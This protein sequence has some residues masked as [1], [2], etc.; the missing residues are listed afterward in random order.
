MRRLAKSISAVL[1]VSLLAIA[2][3]QVASAHAKLTSS[4]PKNGATVATGL[5]EIELD[6]S[7]PL[8][9]TAL[10]VRDAGKH[11]VALKGELPKSFTLVVKLGVAALAPGAYQVSWTAVSEDGHVAKGEIAFTVSGSGQPAK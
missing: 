7:A 6:F 10:H 5:A 8:R 3:P 2:V 9:V 1:L 11:D 4:T